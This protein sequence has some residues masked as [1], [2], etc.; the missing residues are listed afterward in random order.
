MDA[1]KKVTAGKQKDPP[2]ATDDPPEAK[3]PCRRDDDFC[4]LKEHYE[5]IS[6]GDD[7]TST[8]YMNSMHVM[9]KAED[10]SEY[11]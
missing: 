2:A 5:S 6:F 11:C 1:N 7:S 8:D 3:K 9:V 10:V 4:S